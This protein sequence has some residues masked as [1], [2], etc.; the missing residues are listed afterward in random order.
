MILA[1]KG[2]KGD[3]RLKKAALPQLPVYTAT[4]FLAESK[5]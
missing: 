5:G 3:K 1:G 2:E 4:E